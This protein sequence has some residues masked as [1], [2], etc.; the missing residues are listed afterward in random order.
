M[1]EEERIV[2]WRAE[3]LQRAGFRPVVADAL[4]AH[5]DVDLHVALNLV[6]SGCPHDTA[7]RILL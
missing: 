4:A 5:K 6:K 3:E 2:L 7:I 1:S